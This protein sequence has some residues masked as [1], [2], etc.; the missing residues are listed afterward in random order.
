M[1]KRLND[2]VNRLNKTKREET[3]DY[4]GEREERDRLEREDKKAKARE[5]RKAEEEDAKRREAE[6]E[7]KSYDRLFKD[8]KMSSNKQKDYDSDEFM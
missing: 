5:L 2:I 7:R 6:L 4:R 8:E 3:I 1:E